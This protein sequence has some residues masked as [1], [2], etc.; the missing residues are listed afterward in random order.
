MV[1]TKIT[2]TEPNEEDPMEQLKPPLT[3]K[4]EIDDGVAKG[5]KRLQGTRSLW[6]S[7]DQEDEDILDR[8]LR[9]KEFAESRMPSYESES[10]SDLC[11]EWPPCCP[12]FLCFHKVS[13]P[14]NVGDC[15]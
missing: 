1:P 11:S 4:Q 15:N 3:M 12:S 2:V 6:G 10:S 5:D 13:L 8:F 9:V 7:D 14:P